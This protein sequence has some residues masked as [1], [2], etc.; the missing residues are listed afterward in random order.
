MEIV[1]HSFGARLRVKDG[2]FKIIVPDLTGAGLEQEETFPAHEISTVLLQP[3]TS[4]SSDALLYAL[5]HDTDVI[6]LDRLGNPSGRL[7]PN[8]PSTTLNI[9]KNQLA[10]SGTPHALRF[11][12]QWILQ[13]IRH[14]LAFLQKLKA[15]RTAQKVEQIE[16]AEA[17]LGDAHAR[18]ARL[19]LTDGPLEQIAASIRGLEGHAARPYWPLLSQ[20]LPAE[21]QFNGR[22]RQPSNDL[23]NAFI[24]YGYGILYRHVENALWRAGLHP[25]IGF[26]HVDNYQ[27][28]SMVF[29]FI[30][31]YRVWVDHYTFNLFAA[32]KVQRAHADELA[33]GG[34]WLNREGKRLVQ[35]EF[36][37]RF[38]TKRYEHADGK[39]YPLGGLMRVHAVAFAA[40]LNRGM[41]EALQVPL[42]SALNT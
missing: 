23:F 39:T 20:L 34:W 19:S 40:A 41:E 18:L 17:A 21:Y 26:H 25:Y 15:Y 10:L 8:R 35:T 11:A 28:K 4:V 37:E 32:K 29:D 9:W 14:Q 33:G 2:L 30:E 7:L 38:T 22:S 42:A 13:K 36:A 5:E 31:P 24:N 3:G 12:R 16:R 1:L 6:V 27:R